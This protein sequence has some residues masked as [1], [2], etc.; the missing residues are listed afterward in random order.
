M[1]LCSNLF[2][3]LYST[4]KFFS[5]TNKN[6]NK[7][8]ESFWK[9]DFFFSVASFMLYDEFTCFLSDSHKIK[10]SKTKCILSAWFWFL[11]VGVVWKNLQAFSFSCSKS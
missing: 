8:F 11:L 9:F 6:G 4:V 7:N 2:Y 1:Q 3:Q 10:R 5:T